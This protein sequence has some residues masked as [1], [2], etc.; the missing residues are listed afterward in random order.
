MSTIT[1]AD[2][3]TAAT[4][5]H[6]D[7]ARFDVEYDAW[8]AKDRIDGA[9]DYTLYFKEED[10]VM[11]AVLGATR[12]QEVASLMTQALEADAMDTYDALEQGTYTLGKAYMKAFGPLPK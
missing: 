9:P 1:I 6:A 10:A 8:L 7:R 11:E 2:H 12:A 3:E 5:G 4:L